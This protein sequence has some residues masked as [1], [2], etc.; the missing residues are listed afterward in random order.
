MTTIAF[1]YGIMAADSRVTDGWICGTAKKLHRRFD[2]AVIGV[3]GSCNQITPVVEWFLS[4]W[5]GPAPIGR[6]VSALIAYPDRRFEL[7]DAGQV[8]RHLTTLLPECDAVGSGWPIATAAM[9]AGA[10][11]ERAVEIACMLDPHSAPPIDWIK[12]W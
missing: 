12:V 8:T 1:R 3:S 10:S 6:E 7:F 2:G 11:A 9:L 5:D 4:G